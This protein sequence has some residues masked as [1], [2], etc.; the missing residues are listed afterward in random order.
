MYS[1]AEYLTFDMKSMWL[2]QGGKWKKFLLY[3]LLPFA[4]CYRKRI[5]PT[6]DLKKT[7]GPVGVCKKFFLFASH[8][9]NLHEYVFFY[10]RYYKACFTYRAYFTWT[11]N[12]QISLQASHYCQMFLTYLVGLW[13]HLSSTEREREFVQ[14]T[15]CDPHKQGEDIRKLVLFYAK[16]IIKNIRFR[17]RVIFYIIHLSLRYVR[18]VKYWSYLHCFVTF[19]F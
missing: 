18:V 17:T 13:M 16:T 4:V 3:S 1:H 11:E 9:E 2:Y 19:K 6:L 5:L 14:K 8:I 12:R 15:E 10:K 7:L